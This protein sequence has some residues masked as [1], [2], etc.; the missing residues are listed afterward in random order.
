M[1]RRLLNPRTRRPGRFQLMGFVQRDTNLENV[2][3]GY[4]LGRHY[5]L[6]D[7]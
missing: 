3:H 1:K 2:R 7:P 4:R 5:G 6:I